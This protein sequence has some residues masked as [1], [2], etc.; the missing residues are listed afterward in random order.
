MRNTRLLTLGVAL[1]VA[2][3]LSAAATLAWS[4]SV[5]A[6]AATAMPAQAAVAPNKVL[7]STIKNVPDS[8]ARAEAGVPVGSS[9]GTSP[10]I[11]GPH[12]G[13]P[14]RGASSTPGTSKPDQGELN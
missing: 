1:I 12:S 10:V 9:G 7:G 11:S 5:F 14:N 13:A 6:T 3:L 2:G 4:N 8:L